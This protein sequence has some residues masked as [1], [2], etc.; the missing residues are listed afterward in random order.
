MT[1]RTVLKQLATIEQDDFVRAGDGVKAERP[2]FG[3]PG[4]EQDWLGVARRDGE[5]GKF[6]Q[7]S[8]PKRKLARGDFLEAKNV[9]SCLAQSLGVEDFTFLPRRDTGGRQ[10]IC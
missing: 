4:R 6:R 7:L 3:L 9:R 5:C 10:K 1:S 8:L 2:I